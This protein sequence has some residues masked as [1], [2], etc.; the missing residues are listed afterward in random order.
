MI[1]TFKNRGIDAPVRPDLTRL[2][3]LNT[4]FNEAIAAINSSPIIRKLTRDE[5]V[6]QFARYRNREITGLAYAPIVI[7]PA[8]VTGRTT[9]V[10]VETAEAGPNCGTI[11]AQDQ[12]GTARYAG[13]PVTTFTPDHLPAV[14]RNLSGYRA[15]PV[16]VCPLENEVKY[17]IACCLATE[18]SAEILEPMESGTEYA[19]F[20]GCFR[21]TFRTEALIPSGRTQTCILHTLQ[22]KAFP[23]S[24]MW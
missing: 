20:N 2:M 11:I 1:S 9:P 18:V 17:A 5:Y 23:G 10:A 8:L 14:L 21:Y 15:G 6:A 16:L 22:I 4:H 7:Y 24:L 12:H 3:V 13:M 19:S